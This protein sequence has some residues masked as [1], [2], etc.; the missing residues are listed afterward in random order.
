M[1]THYIVSALQI[2]GAC[3]NHCEDFALDFNSN[4][5]KTSRTS[6]LCIKSKLCGRVPM[7]SLPWKDSIS[8]TLSVML[9][10]WFCS[11][12]AKWRGVNQRFLKNMNSV[13]REWDSL[14]QGESFNKTLW[15]ERAMEHWA[16][17]PPVL[18]SCNVSFHHSLNLCLSIYALQCV[19]PCFSIHDYQCHSDKY[20]L[21]LCLVLST[22][23][24]NS[25][26]K[27][28]STFIQKKKIKKS[29]AHWHSWD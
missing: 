10:G 11:V 14:W 9:E 24:E 17:S 26:I 29:H 21:Q 5:T 28:Y 12:T 4:V 7:N 13:E 16:L 8:G 1:P 15:S 19:S 18:P 22:D 27:I 2:C 6:F 25:A 3:I 23:Q 20:P